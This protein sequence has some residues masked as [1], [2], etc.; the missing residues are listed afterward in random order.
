MAQKRNI[1]DSLVRFS[2]TSHQARTID[3]KGNLVKRVDD[4]KT[5]EADVKAV[6]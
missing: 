1:K 5:L 4:P 3:R 6:L 2:I